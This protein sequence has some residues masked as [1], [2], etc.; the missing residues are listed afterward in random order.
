[1]RIGKIPTAAPW[2]FIFGLVFGG[3]VVRAGDFSQDVDLAPMATMAV[4]HNQ[5]M[6]TLDTFA[7]QGVWDITGHEKLDGHSSVYTLLDM[8]FHPDEYVTRNIIKIV[9]VP[10]R[11]EFENLQSI[12]DVE[13]QR[14]VKEG[15][16]SLAFM[17]RPEVQEMLSK[18]QAASVSKSKA[19]NQVVGA[20]NTMEEI[21]RQERAFIPAAIIPPASGG[22]DGL[23][24]RPA[25]MIGDVPD[26]VEVLKEHGTGAPAAPDGYAGKEAILSNVFAA[27][28]GL[29]RGWDS[30]DVGL[31]DQ[32]AK[33]LSELVEQI[34]PEAY[35]SH[36]KRT[37]EVLYNRLTMLTIPGAFFYF[38]A[39]VLFLMSAQA[40]VVKLRPWALAFMIVGLFIHSTG[41]AVRWWLVGGYF[42]PIKNEFE[43][44][45]CSA[46]S[47]AVVGLALELRKGR[48]FFGAAASFVGMLSLVAIFAAPY[49]TDRQ[50]GGEIGQVQGILMSYWLYIHVTMVTASYSLIGM[51][52]LLS[53][54]WLARY[55]FGGGEA[56]GVGAGSFLGTLD[57]C[58][59]VVLQLAFWMLGAGI[60]FGAI[61]ADQSWGR[62]WGWDPKET[63][64]LVTWMVYLIAVHVRVATVNKAWWTAVLGFAGFWV[65][66]FNWIGVNFMLVGLHSYA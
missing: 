37:V 29:M 30:H 21:C 61:W 25:E 18:V 24:H 28:G 5:T 44:V 2:A 16:V 19:I 40:G 42:P 49:V 43:S 9:N 53:S 32:S 4:Q 63:F 65:M 35:P 57:L 12:D 10:L 22:V 33:N 41:I 23:W 48:G 20:M 36:A 47:G 6:K 1:M 3:V 59:L 55:Y 50:I 52:F 66:L 14:I 54:W 51:G 15:T 45:M 27:T 11:E 17:E 64:A 58:N 34:N 46:W 31:V 56:A 13:K 8:S 38:V 62:P 7:R 39:F 60:I 26:L